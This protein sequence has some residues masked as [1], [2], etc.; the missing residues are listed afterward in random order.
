MMNDPLPMVLIPGLRCSARLYTPQ[1]AQLWQ[2]GPVTVSNHTRA[3]TVPAI[4]DDI[5]TTAPPRFALIG[6]SMGGYI[7]F[8]IMRRAPARVV[9]LALLD[10]SAR[11]DSPE[12][13]QRRQQQIALTEAGRYDDTVTAQFGLMVHR[14]RRADAQLWQTYRLMAQETGPE[15]FVRHQRALSQR[16]DSR[17]DLA[18]IKVPTVV[19]VGDADELTPPSHAQEIAAGIDEARLVVVAD[20]GHLSTLERPEAVT[21]A[22]VDFM[23]TR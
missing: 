2:F 3:D 17:P 1:L 19:L 4:A 14:S 20:C 7:A 8:E 9:K 11:A 15:V 22:L 12:Q 6:L 5:L 18:R 10:T 23:T 16:A 13:A 21:A